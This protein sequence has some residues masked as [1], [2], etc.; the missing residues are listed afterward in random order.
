MI[1]CP[2]CAAECPD[3]SRFCLSCGSPVATGRARA[4]ERRVITVLFAD[5]V[6]FTSLSEQLDPEDVD[7]LLREYGMLARTAI[8]AYGGVVEKYIGDAVAGVFGVPKLHED[9]AERA[10][11]GRPAPA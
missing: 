2:A 7:R 8:E 9:D 3:G 1:T 5:L 4:T 10:V 6:G 11:L